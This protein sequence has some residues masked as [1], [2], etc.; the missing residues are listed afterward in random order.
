MFLVLSVNQ[1]ILFNG[2]D[3]VIPGG[4]SKNCDFSDNLHT[5]LTSVAILYY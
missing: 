2:D 4:Y 3:S 1:T 5:Y